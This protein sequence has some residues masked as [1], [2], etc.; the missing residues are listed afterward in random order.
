MLAQFDCPTCH[1]PL[2]TRDAW[3]TQSIVCGHCHT[4]SDVTHKTAKCVSKPADA[5]WEAL[6]RAPLPLGTRGRLRG[7]DYEVIGVLQRADGADR[8]WEIALGSGDGSVTW[9]WVDQGHFSLCVAESKHAVVSGPDRVHRYEGHVLRLYRKGKARFVAASGEFPFVP[10]PDAQGALLEYIAPPYCASFEDGV[11]WV[12]EYVPA[13][14]IDDAFGVYSGTPD[15]IGINQP[16]PQQ[17]SRRLFARITIAAMLIAVLI[18]AF[19]ASAQPRYL[20]NATIDLSDPAHP[21]T[22]SFGPFTLDRAWNAVD[23]E[24]RSPVDNSWA[25]LAVALVN[26][27]TGKTYWTGHGVEFY[28]GIDSD[29]AWS[30]G[31][32]YRITTVRSIPRGSYRM[33]AK[34]ETGTWNG[35]PPPTSAT[36]T[37]TTHPA[38]GANLAL[39]I[40]VI[41]GL[42]AIQVWRAARF[43]ALRWEDSAY[44]QAGNAK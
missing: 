32:Q 20:L 26:E 21:Q 36:L 25:D 15:G 27:E 9:L 4:L 10:N 39:A 12:F 1:R 35:G 42:A 11:W 17:Q 34:G 19:Y 24:L 38:S 37:L 18:H 13:P 43:E 14:E 33:L 44:T 41:V 16:S 29:G 28:R 23:I 8:W 2:Q 5:D 3:G 40:A 22:D 6:S 30:E 31:Q 7:R